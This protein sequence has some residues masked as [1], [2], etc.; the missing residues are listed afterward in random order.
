MCVGCHTEGVAGDGPVT[1]NRP[2][3]P[4]GGKPVSKSPS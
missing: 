4:A 3:S 1:A 2:R